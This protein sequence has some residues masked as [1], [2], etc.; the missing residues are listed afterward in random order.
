MVGTQRGNRAL[1]SDV[2]WSMR[3]RCRLVPALILLAAV[4][5]LSACS[6][7]V[8]ASVGAHEAAWNRHEPRR[9]T[10]TYSQ[11]G[12][13]PTTARRITVERGRVVGS[14]VVGGDARTAP[15]AV[16]VERVFDRLREDYQTADSVG[17]EY[18]RRYGYPRGVS[19]DP[20]EHAI[21][22]KHGYGISDLVP[23]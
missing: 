14:Q 7:G 16:P 8:P 20:E 2:V 18:D 11:N 15:P 17:V 13:A 9:Y 3:S 23:G 4:G 5:G 21:D 12:M 19:V 22:D 6:H 10:F 1:Y